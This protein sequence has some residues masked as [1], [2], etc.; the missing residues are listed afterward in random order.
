M[1]D[2]LRRSN[3]YERNDST[4][5]SMI[6]INDYR[7]RGTLAPFEYVRDDIKRM[8]W[9]NRRIEFIQSLENGIYNEALQD[10]GFK[11]FEK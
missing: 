11:I 4:T 7:L 1:E 3:F 6:A 5:V 2:L 10:N 9:N 8:I